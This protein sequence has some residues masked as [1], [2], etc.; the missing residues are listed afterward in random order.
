M[1]Q[2]AILKGTLLPSEMYI[3]RAMLDQRNELPDGRR[4]GQLREIL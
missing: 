1:D 4:Q 2:N 3:D